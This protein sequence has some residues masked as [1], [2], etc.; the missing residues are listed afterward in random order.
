MLVQVAVE[1]AVP[2]AVL[3]GGGAVRAQGLGSEMALVYELPDDIPGR[4]L[5][6]FLEC[7][8]LRSISGR[9]AGAVVDRLESARLSG[10]PVSMRSYGK[11]QRNARHPEPRTNHPFTLAILEGLYATHS[12]LRL[13]LRFRS[14]LC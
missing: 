12:K 13:P 6:H 4:T 8:S 9:C 14:Q 5:L 2:V 7:H 11:I 1:A 10:W 3:V